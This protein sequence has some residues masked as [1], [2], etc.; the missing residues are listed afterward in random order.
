MKK[1]SLIVAIVLL[2]ALFSG[3]GTQNNIDETTAKT[4]ETTNQTTEEQTVKISVKKETLAEPEGFV[5]NMEAY[6]AKVKESENSDE[7][8]FVFS[9]SE[10][11][12]LL[13]DKLEETVA[14]FKACEDDS[15]HYID[16]V[17]YD[18]DFRNM[19]FYVN[20]KLYDKGTNSTNDM[21]LAASAL[22]YQ[23]YLGSG[24]KTVVKVIYSDTEELV[25]QFVLPMSLSVSQ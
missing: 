20:K 9:K 13:K 5:D 6:G 15:E 10:H 18:E 19:T 4:T 14:R 8:V 16:A 17:E 22:S 3:C 11:D 2:V 23:L 24:Q 21:I 25:Y 12:K 7:Y 1:I